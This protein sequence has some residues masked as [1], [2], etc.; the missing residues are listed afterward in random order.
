MQNLFFESWENVLR[1]VI[2]SAIGYLTLFLFIRISGKR[3]LS[4]FS[5]F[6][7]VVTVSLGSTLSWMILAQVPIIDGSV[8][9]IV[10]IL[11]QYFFAILSQKSNIFEKIVNSSPTLLYYDGKFLHQKLKSEVITEDEILSEVRKNGI[12]NLAEV[13][14]VIME[15]DGNISVIKKSENSGI[16][17]LQKFI[18]SEKSTF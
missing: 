16:S 3:T 6:D 4:K 1:I 5:A 2:C 13:K 15:S 8:A 10:I 9:L 11:L 18:S 17:T 7:F 14:A 12:E